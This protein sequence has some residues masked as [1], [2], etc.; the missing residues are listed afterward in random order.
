MPFLAVHLRP[1][2][3]TS[4]SP[5]LQIPRSRG[6]TSPG[7]QAGESQGTV[8]GVGH[9]RGCIGNHSLARGHSGSETMGVALVSSLPSHCKPKR[10]RPCSPVGRATAPPKQAATSA[11][12]SRQ[13]RKDDRCH[14]P[15]LPVTGNQLPPVSSSSSPRTTANSP[16]ELQLPDLPPAGLIHG[17]QPS[18][19]S[20]LLAPRVWLEQ[21]LQEGEKGGGHNRA[22]SLE[23]CSGEERPLVK[24]HGKASLRRRLGRREDGVHWGS[25]SA[26]RRGMS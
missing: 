8:G 14:R 16:A 12:L 21:A 1:E 5:Q 2:L 20:V 24:E 9:A 11:Q 10:G 26:G 22:R 25:R 15:R 13:G 6:S 18:L 7:L 3:H 19:A 4:S 23:R 17:H